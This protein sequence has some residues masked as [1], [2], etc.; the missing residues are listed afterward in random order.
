MDRTLARLPN[1]P[2][3]PALARPARTVAVFGTPSAAAP[4]YPTTADEPVLR[5]AERRGP[6]RA[7]GF[8]PITIASGDART[9]LR[10]TGTSL[11]AL[12]P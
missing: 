1:R 9:W 6:D 5:F 4:L 12:T 11:E 8:F 10:W 7:P 3:E 2:G